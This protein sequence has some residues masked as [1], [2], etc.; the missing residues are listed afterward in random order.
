VE[1]EERTVRREREHAAAV[2]A[3]FA[4][5][6]AQ[7]KKD[8]EAGAGL[9]SADFADE[10][11]FEHRTHRGRDGATAHPHPDDDPASAGDGGRV[12]IVLHFPTEHHD[13]E[14]TV[15]EPSRLSVSDSRRDL[16]DSD[17][18]IHP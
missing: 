2:T 16:D 8:L 5:A 4:Q 7:A 3:A 15:I 1:Q 13:K 18:C 11:S 6:E 9:G 12:L 10:A 17:N 14:R